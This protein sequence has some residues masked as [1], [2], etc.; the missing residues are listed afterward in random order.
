VRF[1]PPKEYHFTVEKETVNL[2][3]KAYLYREMGESTAGKPLFQGVTRGNRE[4]FDNPG[5]QT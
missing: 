2:N 5:A 1:Q 3:K 4:R